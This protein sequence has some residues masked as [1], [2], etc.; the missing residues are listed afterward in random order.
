MMMMRHVT[1]ESHGDGDREGKMK[2]LLDVSFI[3]GIF[4][5]FLCDVLLG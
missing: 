4:A 3:A 2:Y 1:T 5:M